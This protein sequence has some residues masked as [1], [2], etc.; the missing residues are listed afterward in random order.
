MTTFEQEPSFEMEMVKD[1]SASPETEKKQEIVQ[2]NFT[3]FLNCVDL[4]SQQ[5]EDSDCRPNPFA[6]P[7]EK[8]R[9]WDQAALHMLM[10]TKIMPLHALHLERP[11]SALEKW[12]SEK[13]GSDSNRPPA[14]PRVKAQILIPVEELDRPW[15][16]GYLE[17]C[18]GLTDEMG[19][20]YPYTI[21]QARNP[22]KL[23]EEALLMA[24]LAYLA[25]NWRA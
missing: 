23:R 16:R 6:N 8:G 18:R 2:L 14:P 25:N 21:E 9:R 22:R 4:H 5:C 3:E 24:D 17:S 13:H 1:F 19:A 7:E 10:L 15:A 20:F 11:A 12:L